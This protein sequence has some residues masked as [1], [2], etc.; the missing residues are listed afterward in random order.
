M[1]KNLFEIEKEYRELAQQII[2]AEGELSP[3]LEEQL[4]INQQQLETKGRAYG[5][6]IKERQ[7]DNDILDAEIARL[8]AI[9]K[10]NTRT[11]DKL[12]ETLRNSMEVFGVEEIKSPTLKICFLKSKAVVFTDT[13]EI[14]AIYKSTKVVETESIDKK[15]T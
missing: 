5:Y 6:V 10:R 11:I 4:A 8:T 3:E 13:N 12:K 9:K 7:Y 1:N 2:D 15:Q 14:P